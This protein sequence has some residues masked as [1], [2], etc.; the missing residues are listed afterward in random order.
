MLCMPWRGETVTTIAD[1]HHF[2]CSG[3]KVLHSKS[4][5]VTRPKFA[6]DS[7]IEQGQ[8]ARRTVHLEAEAN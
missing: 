5:E 2:L 8:F 1:V 7:E 6:V 4:D 3:P